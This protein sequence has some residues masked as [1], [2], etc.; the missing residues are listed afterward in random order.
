MANTIQLKRR[1]S[2]VA[3]APAAL[4]SGE[5][6]HN[7]V[8]DTLYVGKGDDG[9]GNATAI[10]P[11]G[12]SG[13]FLALVGTQTVGGA[14]TFSLVPKSSQDA[15]AATDLVRKSQLDAGLAAKAAL[16]HSHA[17][18]DV[19]GLQATLDGKLGA[20]ANAVSASKLATA[21][22]IS[23]AGDLSGSVSFNGTAN[24]TLTAAVADDSHAHVIA[25]VDGLQAALDAKA[26][27]ASPGLTG[28][29]TAPTAASST[30]TVQIATTAFV[31]QAIVDFGPG[32]MLK[33]SYD[34]DNDGKVD[35]A[36]VADAAPWAGITGKPTSFTPASHSH[37]ISQVTSL[38]AALNAKAA[39]ASP[40]LTGT[41][42]APTATAGTNTTQIAST[43]FVAAAIGALIDAAPGAMDTLNELAAALGDDP[44][45]ATTVTNALAGK[46]ASAS[47]LADLPNKVTARSNLGL[48]SMATQTSNSV[49]ITGGAINGVALDGGT[50]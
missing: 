12:G 36:E 6:A 25:N 42:T 1:A 20:S 28:T 27:L 3:G 16:S 35:A 24:V 50:F 7:E 14:K 38:Q 23:L 48:G 30:N 8:D 21:R 33:S 26:S 46:L 47:N 29:P 13:G 32:D 5:L 17:I 41:P 15:S 19:T 10:V 22:T 34:A 37:P 43:A 44:N 45:F 11:L 31:Q 40:A 49:A 4:K 18:G 39:L 2:G 9:A